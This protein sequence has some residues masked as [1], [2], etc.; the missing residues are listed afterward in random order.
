MVHLGA[1][2]SDSLHL[3]A[4]S[5]PQVSRFQVRHKDLRTKRILFQ[6]CLCDAV[7]SLEI[8]SL[9][10]HNKESIIGGLTHRVLRVLLL[11]SRV[12]RSGLGG[13]CLLLSSF[14]AAGGPS[15]KMLGRPASLPVPARLEGVTVPSCRRAGPP[16]PEG[17]GGLCVALRFPDREGARFLVCEEWCGRQSFRSPGRRPPPVTS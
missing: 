16:G 3:E 11:R 1:G 2:G 8:E 7:W 14:S 10:Y 9:F 5:V 17:S 13:G 6:E 12:P 4:V 15:P